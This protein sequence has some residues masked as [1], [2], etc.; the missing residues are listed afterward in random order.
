MWPQLALPT[1][2]RAKI[3][4]HHLAAHG[5]SI[6]WREN[7]VSRSRQHEQAKLLAPI[8]T[9]PKLLVNANYLAWQ[10]EAFIQTGPY[11]LLST[12][13]FVHMTNELDY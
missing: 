2:G 6:Y 5:L 7:E 8:Q 11:T 10:P 1:H 12:K 3:L 4:A 9:K 13:I